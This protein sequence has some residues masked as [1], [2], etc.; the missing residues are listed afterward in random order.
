MPQAV[1]RLVT[2]PADLAAQHRVLVPKYQ[3]SFSST[4]TRTPVLPSKARVS[5]AAAEVASRPARANCGWKCMSNKVMTA[6]VAALSMMA[7]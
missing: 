4:M 6:M 1:G 7:G 5:L 2:D 3:E